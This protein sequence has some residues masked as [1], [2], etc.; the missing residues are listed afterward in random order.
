[1]SPTNEQLTVGESLRIH[2]ISR[3]GFIK[4]CTATASAMALRSAPILIVLAMNRSATIKCRS[5]FG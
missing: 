1:M 3:R 4:F 5:Q 2:G